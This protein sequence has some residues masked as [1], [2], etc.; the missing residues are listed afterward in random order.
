VGKLLAYAVKTGS[1]V[2]VNDHY[3]MDA[4]AV[5]A[6]ENRKL[7]H[8]M[9][10]VPRITSGSGRAE[11][12]ARASATGV[13]LLLPLS[14]EQAHDEIRRL[15]AANDELSGRYERLAE[16]NAE[17]ERVAALS[18]HSPERRCL[19]SESGAWRSAW[20][21]SQRTSASARRM[22]PAATR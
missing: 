3:D 2:S 9:V 6:A 21:S 10:G 22:P 16:R 8:L 12:K 7:R 5:W 19:T 11:G 17:L 15:R 4:L 20:W 13:G 14:L 1:L 18:R